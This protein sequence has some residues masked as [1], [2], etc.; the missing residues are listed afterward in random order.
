MRDG[1]DKNPADFGPDDAI[2][3]VEFQHPDAFVRQGEMGD[4]TNT[5]AAEAKDGDF[6]SLKKLDLTRPEVLSAIINCYKHWIAVADV[7]G[8]PH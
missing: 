4:V 3:P 6:M 7:D 8:F 2:W 1:G 5:S